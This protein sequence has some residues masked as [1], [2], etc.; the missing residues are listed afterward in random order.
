MRMST[1]TSL[2]EF[3]VVSNELVAQETYRMVIDAPQL[4]AR[5]VPGQFMNLS[6]PG[7]NSHVLRIPLSF[8][9]ADALAGTVELIYAVVGEGTRRLSQMRVGDGSSAV[10]PSGAGWWLPRSEGRALLV[11]GGVGLPPILAAAGMLADARVGFDVVVGA[12]TQARL[13]YPDVDDVMR[14]GTPAAAGTGSAE[15]YDPDRALVVTTDDGSAEGSPAAARSAADGMADLMGGR[16]YAQVYTCGPAAM[17]CGVARLARARGIACQ[18]SLERMMGCGFGACSCCN[19]ALVRG[20]NA[21]CCQ[22]GPVFDAEE[23]VW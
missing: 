3:V 10:G 8:K 6:V 11:A 1:R 23:V 13:V 4:A 2:H 16:A 12:R 22:D 19:V 9:R 21:L 18:A 20:G 17:M 14:Y 15:S 7:D 5:I